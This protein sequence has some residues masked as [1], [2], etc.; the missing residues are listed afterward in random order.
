[1]SFSL[2]DII[3]KR[4]PHPADPAVVDRLRV[5]QQ[6][7]EEQDP[8]AISGLIVQIEEVA[9]KLAKND[10]ELTLALL[11]LTIWYLAQHAQWE[12]LTMH[13]VATTEATADKLGSE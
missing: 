11:Q 9:K 3:W 2:F 6:W 1:M 12:Y 10:D 5:G 4:R 13:F 8:N 7:Y